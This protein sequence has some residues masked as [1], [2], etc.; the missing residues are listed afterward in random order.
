MRTLGDRIGAWSLATLLVVTMAACGSKSPTGPGNPVTPPPVTPPPAPTI[1]L[2]WAAL[3]RLY[4]DPLFRG[5]S[6][7]LE[8]QAAAAP[9]DGAMERLVSGIRARNYDL[10]R[11]ALLEVAGARQTYGLSIATVQSDR[12]LL[13]AVYLFEM[14]GW[15]YINAATAN[16]PLASVPVSPDSPTMENGL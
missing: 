8:D 7:L 3:A 2:D 5:L 4:D 16:A 12:M 9:L 1:E 14:R 10:T 11:S 15:G 13:V 6:V